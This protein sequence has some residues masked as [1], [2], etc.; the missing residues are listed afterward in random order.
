MRTFWNR[1]KGPII[2]L[3]TAFFWGTTF[4]AQSLGSD[5]IG[6]FTYNASRFLTTG[7]ILLIYI[8]IKR[9]IKKD[10]YKL[11]DNK[12]K[13][14]KWIYTMALFVGIS[15]FIG[16]SLQQMGINLTKSPSKS[17]FI[18]TLYMLF[19]PI[20]GILWH[21]KVKPILFVYLLIA[22]LGSFLIAYTGSF[23][24]ELGDIL[25]FFCAIGF[26]FQIAII[27]LV[28]PYID[29]VYLSAIEFIVAGLLSLIISIFKE[30]FI[31]SNYIQALPAIFYAAIFS[32]CIAF[33]FQI[34]GQKYT[35]PTIASMIMGLES[36]FS[37]ISGVLVLHEVLLINQWIGSL[38]VLLAVMLS[39]IDLKRRK[40]YAK[41]KE[42]E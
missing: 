26:A 39:Q 16:A 20:V 29:S 41:K 37:L 24:F 25:T 38:L 28:N 12:T 42:K 11:L 10:S 1:F 18:S 15:L 34:I 35:E 5:Y 31:I 33:T 7:I 40:D 23:Y 22:L 17:G 4:V 6:P 21:K 13:S 14:T 3:I 9:K 8:A 36:V 2:L 30:E 19:V 27:D 32:G